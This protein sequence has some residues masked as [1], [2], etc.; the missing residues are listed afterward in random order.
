MKKLKEKWGLDISFVGKRLRM[1][2]NL[3][4]MAREG[5]IGKVKFE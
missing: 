5:L 2:E 1:C 4:R 3:D